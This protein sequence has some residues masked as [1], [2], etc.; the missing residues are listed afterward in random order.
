MAMKIFTEEEVDVAII[1]VGI[2]GR[3][4][5]TNIVESPI[6][7]GVTLIDYDHVHELGHSLGEIAWHKAGIIKPNIPTIT[8]RT[9]KE[10][11]MMVIEEE[12]KRLSSPL[13]IA[14]LL[15]EY[16][17]LLFTDHHHHL[18]LGIA[19][20]HQRE[21]AAMAL[22]LSHLFLLTTQ[23]PSSSSPP[24]SDEI[25]RLKM[26]PHLLSRDDIK[27]LELVEWPGRSHHIRFTFPSHHTNT[28]H[29]PSLSTQLPSHR[30]EE[31]L[32]IEFYLDGAHTPASIAKCASWISSEW[33][34]NTNQSSSSPSS[35]INVIMFNQR[36]SRSSYQLLSPFA[37]LHSSDCKFDEVIFFDCADDDSQVVD[38]IHAWNDLTSTSSSPTR[39]TVVSFVFIYSF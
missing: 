3:Y 17:S 18:S 24:T 6:C 27:G 21:N 11:A 31:L 25:R 12:A 29:Q 38:N 33:L 19:A 34:S 35:S 32:D 1:E 8:V 23:S 10:E 22:S 30:P 4:D 15:E 20:D 14:P 16:E 7:C 13:Y 2:G 39:I 28:D 26:K 9:Q 37:A 36:N 5:S